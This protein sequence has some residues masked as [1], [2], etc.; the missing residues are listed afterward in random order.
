M[1]ALLMSGLAATGAQAATSFFQGFETDTSGWIGPPAIDRVASLYTNGGGYA[2]GISS[3]TGG[4]HARLQLDPTDANCVA[5]VADCSGPFTRWDSYESVFPTG[6]YKTSVDVYL[7]TS[8][9]AN[10]PDYRFDW[11]SAINDSTGHFLQ[12]YVFN[13]GTTPLAYPGGPGFVVNA[14]TNAGRSNAFPENTCPGPGTAGGDAFGNGCRTP[15]LITTSGWY[16]FQHTFTDVGG[17]LDV[18]F[19]VLDSSGATVPGADWTIFTDNS[20][21]VAPG[22]GGHRYGWF[23]NQEFQDLPIDNSSL[24]S[25]SSFDGCAITSDQTSKTITLLADCTTDHT[26]HVPNGWTLDGAGFKVTAIDPAG[27]H[28]LG[29]VVQ[30]DAGI[31]PTT[32]KNLGVTASGL[33]DVCDPSS[34]TDTRLRGILFDNTSG[35]ITNN[36]V[37]GVRQGHSGCQEGNAIEARNFA[38]SPTRWAVSITNNTVTDYMKNAI[39]A[40]GTIAATITGNT[41]VGDGPITYEGQNGIQVGFGATAVVKHNSASL[42]NYTPTSFVACGFLIY[43]A[44][45]VSASNNTFFNN[46][47]NQCNFGKGGGTFKP[48]TP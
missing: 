45:G 2:D 28:F 26:L 12:D 9:A 3:A 32:V 23:A 5:G 48:A 46:E 17:F 11:D 4:W 18:N 27:L 20:F 14:S 39:T 30:G 41:T 43:Q 38:S 44:K 25:R 15:V 22:V 21:S 42:N 24:L 29:A 35:T 1:T 36:N 13:A 34:P 33:A 37:H 40:N 16:T 31:H 6:G 7:D 19:K 8:F 47:R 10:H